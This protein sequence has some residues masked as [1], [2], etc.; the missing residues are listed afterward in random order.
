MRLR[1]S[2]VTNYSRLDSHLVP[3]SVPKGRPCD[4]RRRSCDTGL[5]TGYRRREGMSGSKAKVAQEDDPPWEAASVPRSG[6]EGLSVRLRGS[7]V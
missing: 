7:R 6:P 1:G 5:A 3:R 4:G 2:R